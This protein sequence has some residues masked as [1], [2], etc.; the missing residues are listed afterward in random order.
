MILLPKSSFLPHCRTFRHNLVTI[1]CDTWITVE[2][3]TDWRND[4]THQITKTPNGEVRITEAPV[5]HRDELAEMR[6]M[7]QQLQQMLM[8]ALA[9]QS[10]GKPASA[11]PTVHVPHITSV[12]L[13]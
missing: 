6:M 4:M 12:E 9:G 1:L 8:A 10:K 13:S 2:F 11:K 7:N 3:A 5:V